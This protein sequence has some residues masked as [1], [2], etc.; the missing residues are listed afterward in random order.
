L[1]RTGP[2]RRCIFFCSLFFAVLQV[3]AVSKVTPASSCVFVC[4]T[5]QHEGVFLPVPYAES[6]GEVSISVGEDKSV[7]LRLASLPASSSDSSPNRLRRTGGEA[8]LPFLS[9]S[10]DF[11]SSPTLDFCRTFCPPLS[12]LF[13]E[14]LRYLARLRMHSPWWI[15]GSFEHRFTGYE[16]D[17]ARSRG[18]GFG[19]LSPF[20]QE[21]LALADEGGTRF[22]RRKEALALTSK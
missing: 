4:S 8:G 6:N 3:F 18:M 2:N 5:G 21:A 22:N 10:T 16:F 19:A 11:T 13:H 17:E 20:S 9:A 1:L 12:H 7:L 15:A 14:V